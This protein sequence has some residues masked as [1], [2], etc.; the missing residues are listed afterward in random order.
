MIHSGI[1]A[2]EPD[3]RKCT[4]LTII[5]SLEAFVGVLF[6]SF[7]VAV[8]FAK[9][10]RAQSF[11]QVQFSEPIVIRYGSGVLVDDSDE[12]PR[13]RHS[14][15][16]KHHHHHLRNGSHHHLRNGS[17]HGSFRHSSSSNM[18]GARHCT[19]SV[20]DF[21]VSSTTT[22]DE[23]GLMPCPVLEFQL[24][25]RLSDVPVG[26]IMDATVNMVASIDAHQVLE[27]NHNTHKTSKKK[28]KKKGKK[29]RTGLK[30]LNSSTSIIGFGDFMEHSGQQNHHHRH[31]SH[32]HHHSHHNQ[33]STNPTLP[34]SYEEDATGHLVPQRIFSRLE[35]ETHSHPFMQHTWIVR[36]SLDE[37]SPILKPEIR[38]TIQACGGQ[39]PF[40]MCNVKGVRR[41]IAFDQI[42]VSFNGTSNAD[43]K[44]VY[45]HKVYDFDAVIVGY[46]FVNMMYRSNRGTTLRT[47]ARLINDV[48]EQVGGGGEPLEDESNSMSRTRTTLTLTTQRK[49]AAV[50]MAR[51]EMGL[52]Q[53]PS[54]GSIVDL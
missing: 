23:E 19:S 45:A 49:R 43:G 47:D 51:E 21:G 39:W 53:S 27:S 14:H 22:L 42:L 32:H 30:A 12:G 34:Q 2:N 11:A 29:D 54:V 4:G 48:T 28:R 33:S 44:T 50:M 5:V 10:G 6:A 52:H 9:V 13:D 41:A 16:H 7:M 37:D 31:H 15:H 26:Q 1:S 25:N 3:I 8:T 18:N 46:R 38:E 35:V 40:E 17:H 24:V 36:H 20:S